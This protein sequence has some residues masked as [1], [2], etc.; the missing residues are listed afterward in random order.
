MQALTSSLWHFVNRNTSERPS[1]EPQSSSVSPLEDLRLSMALEDSLRIA[2]SAL[3]FAA[4]CGCAMLMPFCQP[5]K[6]RMRGKAWKWL[7]IYVN[8]LV[9]LTSV[10]VL[11]SLLL[12]I[13]DQG[14]SAP[15]IVLMIFLLYVMLVTLLLVV[16]LVSQ[17]NFI[18]QVTDKAGQ[19]LLNFTT[20]GGTVLVA[21]TSSML[22]KRINQ[23]QTKGKA[24]PVDLTAVIAGAS[25]IAI[26]PQIVILVLYCMDLRKQEAEDQVSRREKTRALEALV[27]MNL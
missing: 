13:Y 10:L 19:H 25:A 18:R 1:V 11:V 17:L 3:V 20:P 23:I 24:E 15:F 21:V 16:S 27:Q 5:Q 8:G 14:L 9:C 26:L 6:L 4:F 22:I 12:W 7:G 2:V